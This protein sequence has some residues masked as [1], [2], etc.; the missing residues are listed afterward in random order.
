M[1]NSSNGR[2]NRNTVILTSAVAI[3]II[4]SMFS[5]IFLTGKMGKSGQK[6]NNSSSLSTAAQNENFKFIPDG[7]SGKI[8]DGAI[9]GAVEVLSGNNYSKV[10][11][12]FEIQDQ[13]GKKLT[14]VMQE[15]TD[16][17]SKSRKSFICPAYNV[18]AAKYKVLSI[19]GD[20]AG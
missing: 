4:I 8:S 7:E 19:K 11:I 10:Y 5:L 13:S 15:I 3:V 14:S 6:D 17:K 2:P 9:K 16:V 20:I 1:F 12:T 18:K